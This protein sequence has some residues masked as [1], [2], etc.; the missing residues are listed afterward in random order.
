MRF[1]RR[2]NGSVPGVEKRIFF[3]GNHRCR[4]GIKCFATFTQ[5]IQSSLQAFPQAGMIGCFLLWRHIG[6]KNG[7]SAAMQRDD[8]YKFGHLH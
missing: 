4:H 6:F 7:S 8:R 5:N 1:I 2:E 3:Q